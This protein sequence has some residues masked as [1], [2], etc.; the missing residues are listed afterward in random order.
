MEVI[1]QILDSLDIQFGFLCLIAI[2][3]F[4]YLMVMYI[5]IPM[6]LIFY[7]WASPLYAAIALSSPDEQGKAIFRFLVFISVIIALYIWCAHVALHTDTICEDLT[8]YIPG[9]MIGLMQKIVPHT[10]P[11]G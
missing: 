10:C 2:P 7:T 5:P 1:R 11:V 9:T 8:D 6:L 3:V 4:C